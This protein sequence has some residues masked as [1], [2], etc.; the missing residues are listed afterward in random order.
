NKGFK[1]IGIDNGNPAVENAAIYFQGN[2]TGAKIIGNEIVANGDAGLM[3][4]YSASISNFVIE[5]NIF[6]GK[7]FLGSNP[8]GYGFSQ[9]FTLPNVPRQLVVIGGG[10]SGTN[11]TNIE[12]RNNLVNGTAG[13]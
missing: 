2:H 11:T 9:Q 8:G 6:S 12:F 5:G 3:T 10:A 7:T 4:E 13:G 1:I